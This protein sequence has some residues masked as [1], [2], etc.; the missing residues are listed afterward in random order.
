MW[1]NSASIWGGGQWPRGRMHRRVGA[2]PMFKP[3]PWGVLEG[4]RDGSGDNARVRKLGAGVR[5]A[6]GRVLCA[7]SNGTRQR[8]RG[9]GRTRSRPAVG[10]HELFEL[11]SYRCNID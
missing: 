2:A 10:Q 6:P 7:T 9:H 4:G 3:C 5:V 1:G 8:W 11:H